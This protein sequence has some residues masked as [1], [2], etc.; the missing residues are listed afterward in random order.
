VRPMCAPRCFGVGGD[1]EQRLGGSLEQQ[2]VDDGL[3]VERQGAD[4]RRQRED[5]VVVGDRQ[6]VRLAFREPLP[7]RRA[8]TLRAVAVAAGRAD[9]LLRHM[10]LEAAKVFA[11]RRIR[12]AAAQSRRARRARQTFS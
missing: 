8:L 3:V 7:R 2:V 4:Q 5:D 9:P 11:G 12:R 1:H 10:E 6:Q